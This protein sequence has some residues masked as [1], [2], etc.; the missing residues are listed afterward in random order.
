MA[1]RE[2]CPQW[3]PLPPHKSIITDLKFHSMPAA[4]P[5]SPPL[6]PPHQPSVILWAICTLSFSRPWGSGHGYGGALPDLT[7]MAFGHR[8]YP[9]ITVTGKDTWVPKANSLGRDGESRGFY[10][11]SLQR[12]RVSLPP[13]TPSAPASCPLSPNVT[14]PSS[15]LGIPQ[16]YC[17]NKLLA[18]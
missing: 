12:G 11:F 1:S 17:F 4:S 3:L 6:P 8:M 2:D 15:L 7:Q 16:S 18:L 14:L 13:P 10:I 9:T 5:L